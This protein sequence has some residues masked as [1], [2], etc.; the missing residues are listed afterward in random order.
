MEI[1]INAVCPPAEETLDLLQYAWTILANVNE[2]DWDHQTDEWQKAV[3]KWRDHYHVLIKRYYLDTGL[4]GT[5]AP[6]GP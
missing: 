4:D 3:V 5:R 1:T 2:G 6:E